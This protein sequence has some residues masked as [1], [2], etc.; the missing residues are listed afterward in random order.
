MSRSRRHRSCVLMVVSVIAAGCQ[1]IG[2]ATLPRDRLDYSTAVL[3]SW[4]HQTLLN[5][6]KLRYADPPLFVDIGQIVS[7]YTLETSVNLGISFD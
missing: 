7:G 3:E 2:P 4:K 6:I 1:S 5:I